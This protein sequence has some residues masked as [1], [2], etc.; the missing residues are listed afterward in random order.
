MKIM[1]SGGTGLIGRALIKSILPAGHEVWVLS[2]GAGQAGLPQAVHVLQWDSRTPAGW[3]RQL[4]EVDAVINLA[5]ESLG[6]GLWTAGR[7]QSILASRLH[8]GDAIVEAFRQAQRKPGVL[9]QASAIGYYG[10][11]SGNQVLSPEFPTRG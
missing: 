7:K 10:E 1:I 2:R 5:G 8:A 4:E 3:A 9:I 11:D 6:D